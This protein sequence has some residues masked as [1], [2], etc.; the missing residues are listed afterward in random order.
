MLWEVHFLAEH[1][2]DEYAR[3]CIHE[4]YYVTSVLEFL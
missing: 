1:S 4:E 2:H 3:I